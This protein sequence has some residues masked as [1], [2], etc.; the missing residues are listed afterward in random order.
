MTIISAISSGLVINT[1]KGAQCYHSLHFC[2]KHSQPCSGGSKKCPNFQYKCATFFNL[3]IHIIILD[4]SSMK[5]LKALFPGSPM[6]SGRA[7]QLFLSSEATLPR[8]S[9]FV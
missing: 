1:R 4:F 2:A 6:T 5:V 3:P 8:L 9:T 7:F